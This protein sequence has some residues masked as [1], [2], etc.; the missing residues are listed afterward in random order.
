[1]LLLLFFP[2]AQAP[3]FTYGGTTGWTYTHSTGWT[4][5]GIS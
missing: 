3:T 5:R 4:Y 2:T 1:M